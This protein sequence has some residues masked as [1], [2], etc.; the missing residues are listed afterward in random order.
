[1]QSLNLNGPTL[2]TCKELE[3]L[4]TEYLEEALSPSRRL[5]FEA[6]LK[7]CPQCQKNLGEMR[8][9][10]SASHRLGGRLN[11]SWAARAAQTQEGFF[12]ALQARTLERPRGLRSSYRKLIPAAVLVVAFGIFGGLWLYHRPAQNVPKDLTIDLSHWETLRGEGQPI[13]QPV[14][15]ERARLNVTIR[16]PIGEEP[17]DYQVEVLQDGATLIQ[18]KAE[19]KL[20]NNITTLHVYLDCS[21][22]KSGA[23]V[24]AIRKA[25]WSRQDFPA[26]V[27]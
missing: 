22:L 27:R 17:G 9:L 12:D 18:A 19:G 13:H 16:L 25:H 3:G 8:A 11:E 14:Q 21:H 4:A 5:E 7:T 23:F 1:M 15:L 6:H 26:V 20:E 2:M 10:I 24:L